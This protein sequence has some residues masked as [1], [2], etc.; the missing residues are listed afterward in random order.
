VAPP[1]RR[2]ITYEPLLA[3]PFEIL[4]KKNLSKDFDPKT[5]EFPIPIKYRNCNFYSVSWEFCRCPRLVGS[6]YLQ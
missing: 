6:G 2:K 4:P 1:S 3:L 5:K